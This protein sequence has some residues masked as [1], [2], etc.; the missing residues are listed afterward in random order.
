M[1][2]GFGNYGTAAVKEAMDVPV[3]SLAEAALAF[4]I[5]FCNRFAVLTTAPR[6]I[7]YTEDLIALLGLAVA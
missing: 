5:P 7:P 3:V 1:L 2:A 6:M 4:A